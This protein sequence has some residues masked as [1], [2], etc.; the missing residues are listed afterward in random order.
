VSFSDGTPALRTESAGDP[1]RIGEIDPRCISPSNEL[2]RFSPRIASDHAWI[3]DVNT[4]ETI[5]KHSQS[6]P[7]T[8]SFK[9]FTAGA[10]DIVSRGTVTIQT[11]TDPVGAPIFYRDVPLIPSKSESGVIKPPGAI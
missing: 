3:P 1:P 2:P 5:K 11:S 6:H 7:A 8:L 9:G 10:T 4:W